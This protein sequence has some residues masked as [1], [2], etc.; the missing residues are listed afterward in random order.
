MGRASL[1]MLPALP[2]RRI[3]VMKHLLSGVAIVAALA[4]AAPVWAQRT[5][6]GVGAPG[7]NQPIPGGPGPSSPSSNLP[8]SF[9]TQYPATDLPPRAPAPAA[10]APGAMAP[11]M[12]PGATTSAMP[13]THRRTRV[14]THHKGLAAHPPSAMSGTTAA[15]LNQEELARLQAGNFSNPPA[16][17]G[18]EPSAS[19]PAIGPGRAARRARNQ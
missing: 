14:S 8:P 7:P 12:A 13:P 5:G 6:P 18:P 17:P 2:N 16:P 1:R 19:N 15:Q 4:F 10:T 3:K 9:G 11:G